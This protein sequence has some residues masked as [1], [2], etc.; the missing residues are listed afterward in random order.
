MR[1]AVRPALGAVPAAAEAV[2]FADRGELLACLAHDWCEG[3]IAARWWW[4]ALLRDSDAARA[5]VAEWLR[6][7]EYVPAALQ[8]LA[9]KRQAVSFVRRLDEGSVSV[10]LERVV[11]RFGL[12]PLRPLLVESDPASAGVG[13]G[14]WK[15]GEPVPWLPWVP[16]T[17]QPELARAQVNCRS[18]TSHC[19]LHRAPSR[20][21]SA[22]LCRARFGI[23]RACGGMPS[24]ETA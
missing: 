19:C 20:G 22:A 4:R 9:G 16:E 21:A 24:G 3:A 11:E 10:V 14:A 12:T 5:V 8:Q 2:L 7:P 15:L 17:A 23:D 6:S 1:E 18:R 13:D